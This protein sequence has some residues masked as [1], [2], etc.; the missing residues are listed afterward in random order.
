MKKL[1]LIRFSSIGDIVLT[2]PVV[3]AI[4]QQGDFELHVLTK[5]QYA[6][7]YD[8]NPNVHMVHSFKKS[9]SE[10]FQNIKNENFDIVVDLQKNMRSHNVKKQL[11]IESYT[12]SKLNIEKWLLVNFKV[13]SLPDIHIVDRYFKAVEP[14]GIFNDGLGLDY[15]IPV[16]DEVILEEV[17]A[18]LKSGYVGF[19][20][21]GQ[22]STKILPPEMVAQIISKIEKPIV[23]LGGPDDKERGDEIVSLAPNSIIINTCGNFNVNQSASLVKNAQVI[24][25]NDTGLMHIAAAFNKPTISIWGNTV[26]DFGMYPYMPQNKSKYFIAEVAS[27]SCRPCSKIGYKKC[28]KKHFKCMMDQ[29]VDAIVEAVEGFLKSRIL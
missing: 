18:K 4:K 25:T 12:F 28:P 14:L 26:P 7:I 22:H 20:I 5:K 17:D 21:G 16:D 23:L 10:C 1:L 2:T 6:G 3:R 27:L 13:N 19:V 9:I 24:I 15:Y 8:S 29:D 11:K